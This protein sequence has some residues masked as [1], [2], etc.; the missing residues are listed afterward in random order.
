MN[1]PAIHVLLW[2]LERNAVWVES[3]AEML[4]ANRRAY[5]DGIQPA[6]V[7]IAMGSEDLMRGVAESLRGTLANREASECTS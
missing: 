2:S 4:S 1:S 5:S 6:G 7:P 3:M